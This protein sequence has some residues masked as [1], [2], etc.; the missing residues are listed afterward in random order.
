MGVLDHFPFRGG[1]GA[2]GKRKHAAVLLLHVLRQIGEQLDQLIERRSV[3]EGI[4]PG[5][6]FDVFGGELLGEFDE[7]AQFLHGR[8]DASFLDVVVRL[9]QRRELVDVGTR[10]AAVTAAQFANGRIPQG[11]QPIVLVHQ[12]GDIGILVAAAVLA[13]NILCITPSRGLTESTEQ[14]CQARG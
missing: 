8:K 4:E 2:I 7:L 13:H 9:Q 11:G 1:E 10:C 3:F 5:V 12:L 14:R 6:Q